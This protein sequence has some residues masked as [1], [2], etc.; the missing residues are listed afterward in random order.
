MMPGLPVAQVGGFLAL[1]VTRGPTLGSLTTWNKL[2]RLNKTAEEKKHS[3]ILVSRL[4]MG[5]NWGYC[6]A[7]RGYEPTQSP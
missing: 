6:M 2:P 1:E 5:G 7:S 3:C 4:I